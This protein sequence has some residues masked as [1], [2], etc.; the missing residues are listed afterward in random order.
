MLSDYAKKEIFNHATTFPFGVA[1]MGG[2]NYLA[3]N[4]TWHG[5]PVGILAFSISYIVS[6]IVKY[7]R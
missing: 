1:V 4:P 2:L 7:S 3:G 6:S 5:V